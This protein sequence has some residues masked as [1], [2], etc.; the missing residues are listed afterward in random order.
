VQV[1]ERGSG[2]PVVTVIGGIHGDEPAGHRIVEQLAEDLKYS[3]D[4]N[5]TA[6]FIIA[7]EPAISAQVRYTETDLN[8][9]FPGDLESELYEERLAARLLRFI[10]DSD[11]VL[12]L[13]TT[14]SAPPPFALVYGEPSMAEMK[15]LTALPVEYA[16]DTSPVTTGTLAEITPDFIGLEAG[17]QFSIE[18][19]DF[20]V[21]AV[22]QFLRVH[23]V[24][25]DEQPNLTD[26]HIVRAEEKMTKGGGQPHVNYKN[27]EVVPQGEVLAWDDVVEYTVNKPNRMP[28]LASE[29]GYEDIF[30]YIGKLERTIKPED[31]PN[32]EG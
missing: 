14:H 13:H 18:A 4:I 17:K 12:A 24:L 5:G 32:H 11:E 7:N 6:R 2:T 31:I 9:C 30:G 20:G 1:I 10:E 22:E 28:L 16:V 3:P 21:E 29:E 23:G 8:R 15:S 19:V 25:E 26:A 27:F